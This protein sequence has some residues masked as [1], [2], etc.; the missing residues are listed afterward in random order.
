MGHI[1]EPKG[2]DFI[3]ESK[4]LTEEERVAISEYIRSYKVEQKAK[5]GGRSKT[6]PTKKKKTSA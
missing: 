1:K 3:I 6:N 4:P 5:P 2:V